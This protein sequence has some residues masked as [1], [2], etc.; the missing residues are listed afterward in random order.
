MREAG[1]SQVSVVGFQQLLG[2][3]GTNEGHYGVITADW[4]SCIL[5]AQLLFQLMCVNI[6]TSV[7]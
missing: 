2:I 4:L 6:S 7:D 3:M 1:H 5:I